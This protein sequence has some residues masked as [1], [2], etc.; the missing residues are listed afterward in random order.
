MFAHIRIPAAAQVFQVDERDALEGSDDLNATLIE[1][2]LSPASF[3]RMHAG[4]DAAGYEQLLVEQL[5]DPPAF[6]LVHLGLGPDGH[7]ASLLPDDPVLAV[8]D[9]FV[10]KA[11]PAGGFVRMT[12]TFPVLNLARVIVFVVVGKPKTDAVARVLSGD[13][14]MPAARLEASDV[15]FLLDSEAASRLSGA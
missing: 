13:R 8:A 15:R 5:G 10:A 1:R 6:D 9:R 12:L 14:S 7:T 2:E 11:G 3:H 4:D